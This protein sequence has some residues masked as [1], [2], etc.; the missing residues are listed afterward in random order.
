[1]LLWAFIK[2][3][4]ETETASVDLVIWK[5]L[6]TA[7]IKEQ[8]LRSIGEFFKTHC[9]ETRDC[10]D[11]Q[12]TL[13]SKPHCVFILPTAG[14]KWGQ[15]LLRVPDDCANRQSIFRDWGKFKGE[16][17]GGNRI[18]ILYW[19]KMRDTWVKWNS[20]KYQIKFFT[21]AKARNYCFWNALGE[22]HFLQLIKHYI[23][24]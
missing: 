14:K 9:E 10:K 7:K 6:K 20:S 4:R 17:R 16:C 24:W 12:P 3:T 11:S 8:T 22:K 13:M 15:L 19:S 18:H 5:R 1:M 23:H 2:T 21:P